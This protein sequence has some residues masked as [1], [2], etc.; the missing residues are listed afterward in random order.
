M[1]RDRGCRSRSASLFHD[2]GAEEVIGRTTI[3]DLLK[4]RGRDLGH[5]P[6]GFDLTVTN[7]NGT[8]GCN[9]STTSHHQYQKGR[10]YSAPR[11]VSVLSS[12]QNPTHARPTSAGSVG[13]DDD[14]ANHQYDV[15]DFYD[16]INAG[17]FPAVNF[18]KAPGYQDGH[19][20]YSDPLDEQAWIVG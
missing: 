19:A 11:A 10:L 5:H 15:H 7:A 1:H 4:C 12:T 9:R 3:G 2:D 13:I 20:G 14:A 17:N 8:T 6:E 16:A 18:L